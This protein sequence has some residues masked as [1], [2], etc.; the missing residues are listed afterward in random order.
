MG[1]TV[2][3]DPLKLTLLGNVGGAPAPGGGYLEPLGLGQKQTDRLQ[4][5]GSGKWQLVGQS[6]RPSYSIVDRDSGGA[7]SAA[8]FHT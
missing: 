6:S 2:L 8:T 5:W 7:N 4:T 3:L 1:F